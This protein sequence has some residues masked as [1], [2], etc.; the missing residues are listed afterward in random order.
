[1]PLDRINSLEALLEM[2]DAPVEHSL[3]KEI[4]KI[5]PEYRALIEAS[6]FVLIASSGPEGLDCS[7][8]GDAAG[9]VRIL[10]DRTL[11]IPDRRGNNRLDTLRNIVRDGRAAL[12]L[13]IPGL[14]ETVRVN[15]RAFLTTDPDLLETF[16][17]DGKPPRTV[18]IVEIESLYF[19]CARALK[20]SRLW[21][22]EHFYS[23]D[24]LPSAGELTKS[25][26]AEFDAETYDAELQARQDRTLY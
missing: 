18:I 21:D 20:R 23:S 3:R 6:P 2:Y 4:S 14:N 10:D 12:L 13:L 9:F 11:A 5:T 19:Q 1:M 8:R 15:G 17:V 25:A 22:P 16:T 7:P 24:D 26:F